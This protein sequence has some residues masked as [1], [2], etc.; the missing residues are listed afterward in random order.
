MERDSLGCVHLLFEIFHIQMIICIYNKIKQRRTRT[1]TA[2]SNLHEFCFHIMSNMQVHTQDDTTLINFLDSV[3]TDYRQNI[4]QLCGFC[5]HRVSTDHLIVTYSDYGQILY[6]GI[7]LRLR[8][9]FTFSN[10]KCMTFS[11]YLYVIYKRNK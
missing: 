9:S 6:I 8:R 3:I 2:R 11:E 7:S 4:N 5:H 10:A 1:R